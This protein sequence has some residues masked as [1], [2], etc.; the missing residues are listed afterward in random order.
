MWLLLTY[1]HSLWEQ[2]VDPDLL[3]G[4]PALNHTLRS[5]GP[6]KLMTWAKHGLRALGLTYVISIICDFIH[7]RFHIWQVTDVKSV[8]NTVNHT[9]THTHTWLVSLC[10]VCW[11]WATPGGRPRQLK[12]WHRRPW[13]SVDS[14]ASLPKSSPPRFTSTAMVS[15]QQ[16][17]LQVVVCPVWAWTSSRC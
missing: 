16:V 6:Q 12:E 14:L 11:G 17:A 5:G 1:Q 7:D 3:L 9:H 4:T 15:S 10:L 2:L 8:E 13:R